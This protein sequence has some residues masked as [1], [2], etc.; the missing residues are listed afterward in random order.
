MV[1]ACGESTRTCASPKVSPLAVCPLPAP[2]AL[3][4]QAIGVQCALLLALV[5]GDGGELT[6]DGL[7]L[8]ARCNKYRQ[9]QQELESQLA[10]EQAKGRDLGDKN[11]AL[12]DKVRAYT[13]LGGK[14]GTPFD[15]STYQNKLQEKDDKIKQL[16]KDVEVLKKAL[17]QAER[18]DKNKAR[19]NLAGKDHYREQA[20]ML[21]H[22]LD[23]KNKEVKENQV[24]I[25]KL[26]SQMRRMKL[27]M[28]S[29]HKLNQDRIKLNAIMGEAPIETP[30]AASDENDVATSTFLTN[31][32]PDL[33]KQAS[34][35]S[36]RVSSAASARPLRPAASKSKVGHAG[37]VRPGGP[38]AA[39]RGHGADP[40][41]PPTGG[42]A[43]SKARGDAKLRKEALAVGKPETPADLAGMLM[44]HKQA[45]QHAS[46]HSPADGAS[47]MPYGKTTDDG[48]PPRL[49]LGAM[50]K[51][52]AAP[53]AYEKLLSPTA[54]SV[55]EDAR[56]WRSATQTMRSNITES[57]DPAS[58]RAHPAPA[59]EDE[60]GYE[61]DFESVASSRP[62]ASAAHA[63]P[64][65]NGKSQS[66]RVAQSPRRD[67]DVGDEVEEEDMDF[68]L[69]GLPCT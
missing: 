59:E 45:S 61:D 20:Q 21:D 25:R 11:R 46:S 26:Q 53:P 10:Q 23:R 47:F 15:P 19:E 68:L 12:K 69:A 44:A 43:P 55:L 38:A 14:D 42:Q 29:L 28:A 31:L 32:D 49:Q 1:S 7:G 54:R 33:D 50:A 63:H 9:I 6:A 67:S 52:A 36:S 5:C 24:L 27:E 17:Q 16:E 39:R 40:G 18:R 3:A 41:T 51:A 37:D 8:A 64:R 57:P 60:G 30:D 13:A 62:P 2:R 58:G 65:A 34:Q 66:P 4:Q 56:S 22:E 35:T 48:K